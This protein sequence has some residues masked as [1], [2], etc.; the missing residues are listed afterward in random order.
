MGVRKAAMLGYCGWLGQR[1][2]KPVRLLSEED[3]ERCARG[4]DG[5]L[6]PWGNGFDWAFCHGAPSREERPWLEPVG[7]FPHDTS[8][9][10][11]R[12]LAGSIRELCQAC[13]DRG[14]SLSRGGSWYQSLA[15]IFRADA[16][17]IR[18]TDRTKTTDVGFRVCYVN[19]RAERT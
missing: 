18:L 3:W 7:T 10:G 5:R 9:F 19:P 2:G 8:P 11:V 13:D 14:D 16:R 1:L 17:L 12:D 6:Y 15:L 4:A